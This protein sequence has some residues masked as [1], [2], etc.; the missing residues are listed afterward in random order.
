MKT[1]IFQYLYNV[2]ASV[3]VFHSERPRSSK[4]HTGPEYSPRRRQWF[5]FDHELVLPE[6]IIYFE[7]ITGVIN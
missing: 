2:I 5:V 7:Y 1:I 3:C 6:Y 4:T